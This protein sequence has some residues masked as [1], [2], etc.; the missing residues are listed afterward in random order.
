MREHQTTASSMWAD[1]ISVTR[2][3]ETWN[4]STFIRTCR[5]NGHTW[6][7]L[8]GMWITNK[9]CQS[10]DDIRAL[11]FQR[12]V[13]LSWTFV[14]RMCSVWRLADAQRVCESENRWQRSGHS[15]G[16]RVPRSGHSARPSW[17]FFVSQDSQ[18]C[19]KLRLYSWQNNNTCHEHTLRNRV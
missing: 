19:C 2:R 1:E 11:N 16:C 12:F 13:E 10:V 18:I 3:P 7:G 9:H 14:T 17:N 6:K 5:S 15:Y 8:D 4:T